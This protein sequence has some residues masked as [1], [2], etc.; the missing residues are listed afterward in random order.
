MVGGRLAG[1]SALRWAD[2]GVWTV[3]VILVTDQPLPI[4]QIN[5]NVW[6]HLAL[7]LLV[8]SKQRCVLAPA[9]QSYQPLEDAAQ[10]IGISLWEVPLRTALVF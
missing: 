4:L 7:H 8:P 6:T 10:S 3:R 1:S 2:S 9:C 5:L